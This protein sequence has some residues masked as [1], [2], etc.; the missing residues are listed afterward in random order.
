MSHAEVTVIHA[1][2]PSPPRGREKIEW[3]LARLS[4]FGGFYFHKYRF[5]NESFDELASRSA[6]HSGHQAMSFA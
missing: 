3:K 4:Q 5:I 6:T 1:T 2:E